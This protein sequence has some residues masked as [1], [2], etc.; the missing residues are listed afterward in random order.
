MDKTLADV[1]EWAAGRL[2]S[3]TEPPWTYYRLMQLFDALEGL[4]DPDADLTRDRSLQSE[5]HSGNDLQPA[6]AIY[7]LDELRR[8]RVAPPEPQPT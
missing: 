8:R 6:A 5:P 7:S 1:Q 4:R 2:R 3:G